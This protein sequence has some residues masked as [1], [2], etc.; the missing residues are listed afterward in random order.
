MYIH[1]GNNKNVRIKNI[2]GI[3]DMDNATVSS[4]TRT[5]LRLKQKKYRVE[6]IS[7]EIPKS[8]LLYEKDKKVY[9]F[10]AHRP[11]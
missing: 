7:N 1:V 6:S 5:F 8:F 2:I 9:N 4:I 10:L 11:I 3:F